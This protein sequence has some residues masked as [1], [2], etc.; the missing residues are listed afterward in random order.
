[1]SGSG[2]AFNVKSE[3][4]SS[5]PF[6]RAVATGA[7]STPSPDG[8]EVIAVLEL[9]VHPAGA[10]DFDTRSGNYSP[11]RTFVE[12]YLSEAGSFVV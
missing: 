3:S 7:N 1:M 10:F 9:C 8:C 12:H 4:P 6:T 11:G 5:G 2:T